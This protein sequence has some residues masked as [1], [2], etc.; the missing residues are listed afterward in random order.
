MKELEI[1]KTTV[2]APAKINFILKVLGSQNDGFHQVE[3]LMQA[4][5]LS[6]TVNI[7]WASRTTGEISPKDGKLVEPGIDVDLI[8]GKDFLPSSSSNLAYKAAILMHEKFHANIKDIVKIEVGK[9]IP[10]AAG[11]AGGSADGAAVITGLCRLWHI[12]WREC[13]DLAKMLG[14]DVPF[15]LLSQNGFFAALATGTGTDLEI[16]SPT[17]A[18]VIIYNGGYPVSTKEV[19]ENWTEK[20]SHPSSCKDFLN[21]SSLAEKTKYMGNDLDFP[22]CRCFERVSTDL[23]LLKSLADNALIVQ[24]SG[25]GPTV[26]AVFNSDDSFDEEKIKFLNKNKAFC[27]V[28]KTLC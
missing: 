19:Y 20:D 26:F 18:K 8:P 17:D 27:T 10:V 25:S 2:I 16:V 23:N 15:S 21:A 4:I 14:S 13:M 9:N 6:D 28:C 7:W 22:A 3:N 11:L 24:L 12:D 1:T 5:D